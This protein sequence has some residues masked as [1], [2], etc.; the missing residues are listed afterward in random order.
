[1]LQKA[2]HY[3]AFTRYPEEVR[4]HIYTTS[5]VESV[6]SLVEKVRIKSGGYFQSADIL[7]LNGLFVES[8]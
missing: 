2:D 5:A 4:K 6:N 1:M 3:F 8:I 7:E